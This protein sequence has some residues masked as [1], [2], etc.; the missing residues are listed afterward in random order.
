MNRGSTCKLHTETT[1]TGVQTHQ[2][3]LH[4]MADGT[5]FHNDYLFSHFLL[6]SLVLRHC[7]PRSMQ[8]QQMVIVKNLKQECCEV[9]LISISHCNTKCT[10]SVQHMQYMLSG[11]HN[12]WQA[13]LVFFWGTSTTIW[14]SNRVATEA[15]AQCG[16]CCVLTPACSLHVQACL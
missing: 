10:C 4:H 5:I 7:V 14:A 9:R 2:P 16:F 3:L 8:L 15:L 13:I 11:S 12:L 6:C 1:R